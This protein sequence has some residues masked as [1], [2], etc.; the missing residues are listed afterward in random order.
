[1]IKALWKALSDEFAQRASIY[2]T[3][4]LGSGAVGGVYWVDPYYHGGWI[5]SYKG[6]L[7]AFVIICAIAILASHSAVGLTIVGTAALVCASAFGYLY[8]NSA[9]QD[10]HWPFWTW[11]LHLLCVA[12]IVGVC[13]GGAARLVNS[14]RQ[15]L[16]PPARRSAKG[17]RARKDLTSAPSQRSNN[18]AD[19]DA[20][21]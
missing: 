8:K 3:V 4:L 1:M 10:D 6:W 7:F 13:V 12:L 17:G 16:T 19:D 11:S 18:A 5:I 2:L 15:R 21:T 20:T 14:R 9:F